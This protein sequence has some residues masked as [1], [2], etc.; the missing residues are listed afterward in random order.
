MQCKPVPG[1]YL[2]CRIDPG[3]YK[4]MGFGHL[5]LYVSPRLIIGYSEIVV[6][7]GGRERPGQSAVKLIDEVS[8]LRAGPDRHNYVSEMGLI[9]YHVRA[10]GITR[11]RAAEDEQSQDEPAAE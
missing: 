9:H 7:L 3:E 10:W 6:C 11:G 8:V 4:I 1:S 2:S 5:Q